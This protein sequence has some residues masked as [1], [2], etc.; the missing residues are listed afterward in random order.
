[1]IPMRYSEALGKLISEKNLK[2]KI[3]CQTPCKGQYFD[4][5]E[6][7]ITRWPEKKQKL[8]LILSYFK[9]YKCSLRTWGI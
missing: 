8:I 1:M 2:S 9:K 4:I 5:I 3:S 7:R 6:W